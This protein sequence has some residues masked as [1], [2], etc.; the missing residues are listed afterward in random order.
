MRL[1]GPAGMI[2]DPPGAR[3]VTLG[4]ATSVVE[5]D[6]TVEVDEELETTALREG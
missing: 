4:E 6:D 5:M 3:G 1:A 2:G